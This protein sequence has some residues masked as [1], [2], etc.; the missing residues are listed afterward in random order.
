MIL[1]AII[2]LF[3][4]II[5]SIMQG[6]TV[7]FA[8]LINAMLAVVE[9]LVGLVVDGFSI[10]RVGKKK[11]E[12]R[13][14]PVLGVAIIILIL[15]AVVWFAIAP[16]ILNREITLVAEDGHSLPFA[17]LIVRSGDG[18][19]HVRTDNAG[20]VMIPRFGFTSVSINDPRYV[21]KTWVRSEVKSEIVVRRTVLGSG[22]DKLADKLLKPEEK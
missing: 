18:D 10:G 6:A 1:D 11:R 9:A 7:V 5:G 4:S 15:G 22:L 2:A 14:S 19:R 3:G 16:K 8:P 13:G 21:E 20:K 12:S 17:A